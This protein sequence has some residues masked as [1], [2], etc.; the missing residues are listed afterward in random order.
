MRITSTGNVGIGTTAPGSKLHVNGGVQVGTPTGGDQGTGNINVSGNIYRNG[1][2]M[3]AKL[4][5]AIV[6]LT[7]RVDRL[8]AQ[9]RKSGK[10]A[11]P[12]KPAKA[13]KSMPAKSGKTRKE[14]R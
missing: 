8:E 9:L 4:E 12:A 7:K 1:T 3:L 14:R 6:T 11:K 2:P 10:P 13:G 5:K